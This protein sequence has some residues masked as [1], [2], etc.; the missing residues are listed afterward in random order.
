MIRVSRYT[1]DMLY[2][3][4]CP[5][6]TNEWLARKVSKGGFWVNIFGTNQ[7]TR[8][9]ASVDMTEDEYVNAWLDLYGHRNNANERYQA[10]TRCPLLKTLYGMCE[11]NR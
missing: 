1:T 7:E 4:P 8:I 2:P 9:V 5:W 3:S 10:M 6:V 11:V